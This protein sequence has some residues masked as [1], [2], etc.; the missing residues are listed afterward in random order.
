MENKAC[1][2]GITTE[3]GIVQQYLKTVSLLLVAIEDRVLSLDGSAEAY[4]SVAYASAGASNYL[5]LACKK[6]ERATAT[7]AA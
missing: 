3:I 1:P 2:V 4:N 6:L 5:A 7:I